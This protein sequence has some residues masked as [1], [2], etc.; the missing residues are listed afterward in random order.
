MVIAAIEIVLDDGMRQ[1]FLCLT[2][3]L[4]MLS[5]VCLLTYPC[6]MDKFDAISLIFLDFLG[7]ILS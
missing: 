2:M 5:Y 6:N 7:K 1:S 3:L 4:M